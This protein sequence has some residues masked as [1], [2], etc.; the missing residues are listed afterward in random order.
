MRLPI[1]RDAQ[2]SRSSQA[3]VVEASPVN[4]EARGPDEVPLDRPRAADG[5]RADAGTEWDGA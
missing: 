4:L 1:P 2:G 3:V 5:A